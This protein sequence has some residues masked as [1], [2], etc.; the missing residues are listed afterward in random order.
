M[1][2]INKITQPDPDNFPGALF[3]AEG[4]VPIAQCQ[5]TQITFTGA[6]TASD[7]VT[8]TK[9][10]EWA[11]V[12]LAGK[13]ITITAPAPDAG[14]YNVISNTDDVVTTDHT[15]IAGG[16]AG[17]G[18]IQDAGQAYLT[19]DLASFARFIQAQGYAYT[20]KG[21]QLYTDC[22]NGTMTNACSDTWN[23]GE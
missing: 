11:G 3:Q 4:S 21:G 13:K 17:A 22:P 14:T 15:F 6:S 10:G 20:I 12:D 23:P 5:E 19:R 18:T 16:A 7:Q 1:G 8:V 2:S 9:V